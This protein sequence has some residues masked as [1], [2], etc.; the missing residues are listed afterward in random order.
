MT[1]TMVQ[2]AAQRLNELEALDLRSSKAYELIRE[3]RQLLQPP[4]T[5]REICDRLPGLTVIERAASIGVTKQAL[6]NYIIGRYK[7]K[8]DKVALMV[9]L[10][11][12]PAEVIRAAGP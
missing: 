5:M 3:M 7:P 10:T 11:G 8:A 4:P 6:H 12:V 1:P 9:K 2:K